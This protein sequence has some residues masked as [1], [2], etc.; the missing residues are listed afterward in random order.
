MP[1][2]SFKTKLQNSSNTPQKHI[3]KGKI[4]VSKEPAKQM[5]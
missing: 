4:P 3:K 5:D 1:A 2:K